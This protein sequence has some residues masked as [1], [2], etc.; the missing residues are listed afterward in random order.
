MENLNDLRSLTIYEIFEKILGPKKAMEFFR[1]L[2]EAIRKGMNE[3][4]LKEYIFSILCK[5]D[6]SDIDIYNL[7]YIMAIHVGPG[8]Y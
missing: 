2:N 5:L 8:R 6:V 1:L 3:K 7:S 4:E